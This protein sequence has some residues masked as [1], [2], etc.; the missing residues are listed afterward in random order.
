MFCELSNKSPIAADHIP[1][2]AITIA[3]YAGS[4]SIAAYAGIL[5]EQPKPSERVIRERTT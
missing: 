3:P 1:F 2:G 4:L 5:K